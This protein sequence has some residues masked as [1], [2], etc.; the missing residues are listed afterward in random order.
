LPEGRYTNDLVRLPRSIIPEI[1][2]FVGLPV[3]PIMLGLK[4]TS[5]ELVQPAGAMPDAEKPQPVTETSDVVAGKSKR[6][7]SR[8][9][10]ALQIL[11]A[12]MKKHPEPPGLKHSYASYLA[13]KQDPADGKQIR[14]KTFANLMPEA[15]REMAEAKRKGAR[16]RVRKAFPRE[17]LPEIVSRGKTPGKSGKA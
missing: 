7:P 13:D 16:E 10:R 3:P 8:A 4:P 5:E 6:P 17:R 15:K 1:L 12:L 11:L 14:A 9:G 2:R